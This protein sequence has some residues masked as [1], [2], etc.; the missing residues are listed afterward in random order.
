[1]I[2]VPY[3]SQIDNAP[4]HN[5]CGLAC[6]LMLSRWNGKGITNTVTQL[7]QKYDPTDDGTTPANLA[8][9]LKDLGLPIPV[10]FTVSP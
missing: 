9:A 3:V 10:S 2:P 5:E 4:R 8:L 7:S 1:M 6:V